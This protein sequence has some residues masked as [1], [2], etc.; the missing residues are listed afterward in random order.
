MHTWDRAPLK[1]TSCL[2]LTGSR[3]SHGAKNMY[4]N[5]TWSH[6]FHM[7]ETEIIWNKRLTVSLKSFLMLQFDTSQAVK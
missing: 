2:N 6:R 7:V 3:Y 4:C 5:V 1:F